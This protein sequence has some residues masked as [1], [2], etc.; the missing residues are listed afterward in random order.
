VLRTR[1]T[2]KPGRPGTKNLVAEFGDRLLCV[3]YRYDE[4]RHIRYKTAE[5]IVE[6]APWSPARPFAPTD[7]VE[8]R[9]RPQER[10]LRHAARLLG[11]RHTPATHTWQTTYAV[12]R[13]LH[14]TTRA[15]RPSI[16]YI[17]HRTNHSPA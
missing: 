13:I 2:L 4:D 11:A 10:T 9:I 3:R 5:V 7:V 17:A 8:L 6:E 1:L 12:A 15:T 14:L 16:A